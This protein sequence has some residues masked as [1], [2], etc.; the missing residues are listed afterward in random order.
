MPRGFGSTI[1]KHF[2]IDAR[3][4]LPSGGVQDI[5]NNMN[6][7]ARPDICKRMENNPMKKTLLLLV[8]ALSLVLSGCS[9]VVKDPEVDA[10]QVIVEINGQQV[11]KQS[12]NATYNTLLSQELQLQQM[13]KMYG[14]QAPAI[15]YEGL[16]VKAKD[17]AI[18]SEIIRQQAEKLNMQELT[19]E[20]KAKLA[21]DTESTYKN[22]LEQL[23]NYYLKDTKLEG[24]ALD[25]ELANLAE[26]TGN[27]KESI[28]GSLKTDLV[29]GKLRS[30]TVKDV[31]VSEEETRAEYDAKV[32]KDK[33]A[34]A[35]K[36]DSY[37]SD[38]NGGKSPYFAPEGYRYVKQVLVKFLAEDETEIDRI[39]GEKT[40]ADTELQ[41]AR[42]AK[43]ANETAMA[44][45]G[46]TEDEK[47][48]L[49][50]KVPELDAAIT[51][52]QEKADKLAQDL[53]AARNKGYEAILPKAQEVYNRA[54]A[55][56]DFDALVKEYNEDKGMPEKGYAVREGF[57]SFDEA[58]VKPAMALAAIGDVAEPSQGLYG[59]YIV[60][61]AAD[62]TPGPVDYDSVKETVHKELLDKKQADTW[63]AAITGWTEAADIKEHMERLSN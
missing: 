27:T 47:K 56:E 40:T 1:F 31:A 52:A 6:S 20:E 44:R 42:D 24:E 17:A 30:E 22:T 3:A 51:A 14:M 9:L 32:E 60:Q 39:Q 59:Y 36:P 5:I 13:Y 53:L 18:R 38:V 61:Y 25:K 43:T 29:T 46:I 58:F 34:Y 4:F 63:E 57:A 35:E 50:D 33:T 37:G 49:E 21:E 12:F 26:Q 2:I 23:K 54:A 45:E 41:K 11:D 7:R 48:A 19:E 28:E 8:L 10:R 55:K 62:I 15:D 16:K